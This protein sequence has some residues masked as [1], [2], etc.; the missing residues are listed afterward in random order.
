MGKTS[1]KRAEKTLKRMKKTRQIDSNNLRLIIQQ[2]LKWAE[3]EKEKGLKI[4][5]ENQRAITQLDGIILFIKD[6]LE[7]EE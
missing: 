3:I 2:K 7:P 4:I 6:L 1:K 5:K